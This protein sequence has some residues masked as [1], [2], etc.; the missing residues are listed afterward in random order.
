MGAALSKKHEFSPQELVFCIQQNKT[1]PTLA[2]D[3]KVAPSCRTFEEHTE[4]RKSEF[5]NTF[6]AHNLPERGELLNAN[7]GESMVFCKCMMWP[8]RAVRAASLAESHEES[9]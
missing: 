5:E 9:L 6:S 8:V 4:L 3:G 2:E 1:P 7:V